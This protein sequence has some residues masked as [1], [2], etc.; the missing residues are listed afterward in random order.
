[1]V[2]VDA[3]QLEYLTKQ[4]GFN[5]ET[6]TRALLF[7]NN[8]ADQA[9]AMLTDPNHS[10]SDS[11][12]NG[13]ASEQ[14]QDSFLDTPSFFRP[15]C[16]L[17][18]RFVSLANTAVFFFAL[19]GNHQAKG[20]KKLTALFL[21]YTLLNLHSGLTG[22]TKE[23]HYRYA[24]SYT[25]HLNV[26]VMTLILCS[27]LFMQE[28]LLTY[29]PTHLSFIL[30][31]PEQ[32]ILKNVLIWQANVFLLLTR[33]YSIRELRDRL[34]TGSPI[35]WVLRI[36]FFLFAV[37]V[38][39]P[40]LSRRAQFMREATIDIED[41]VELS[42]TILSGFIYLLHTNYLL[43]GMKSVLICLLSTAVFTS[44]AILGELEIIPSIKGWSFGFEMTFAFFVGALLSVRYPHMLA[45]HEF[46]H[47]NP[48][49]MFTF[50]KD[51]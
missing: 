21:F 35:T 33:S 28:P 1:M 44:Y 25:V 9:I 27:T 5:K 38:V 12:A 29:G 40:L 47:P 18:D 39:L 50:K 36:G 30:E 45:S 15:R 32:D 48:K 42:F 6:A 3:T 46:Q 16:S 22:E 41:P 34:L 49:Q 23:M 37:I 19:M 43:L 4:L 20:D 2:E 31:G 17:F 10:V 14:A 13:T 51:N 11:T 24:A 26:V 8:D 7:T